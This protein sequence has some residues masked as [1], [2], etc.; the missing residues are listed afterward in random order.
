MSE[1]I[2]TRKNK[3]ADNVREDRPPSTPKKHEDVR[4]YGSIY[5]MRQ[6]SNIYVL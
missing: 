5:D 4:V 6:W 3:K 2:G 1:D